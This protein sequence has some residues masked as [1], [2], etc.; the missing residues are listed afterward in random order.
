MN[1]VLILVIAILVLNMLRGYR[2]GMLRILFSWISW[3]L[4][5]LFVA[6]ARPHINRGLLD[7]T[8]IY[9][10]IETQCEAYLREKAEQK[11][12]EEMKDANSELMTLGLPIPEAML[13]DMMKKTAG[14]ANGF[15]E[16]SGLYTQMAASMAGFVVNGISFFISLIGAW[17]VVGILS[18]FLNIV[19]KIPIL[20]GINQI[21]GIFAGG[22][23]GLLFV[24]VAFYMIALCSA[25]ELGSV[26][27][28]Q[29]YKN[30]FLTFLYE[31]NLVL[32]L[33]L[34]W[35]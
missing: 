7:H 4:V 5:F 2:K 15:L 9:Q 20:K 29:I 3:I 17:I 24:W 32:F 18:H 1:W 27:I 23:Y 35:L 8:T 30:E 16:G 26:M 10:K 31:N 13:Q 19:S 25:G 22:I 28:S 34:Y 12:E 14:A 6:L 11:T 21:L 33:I